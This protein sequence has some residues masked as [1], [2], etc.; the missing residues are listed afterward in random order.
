MARPPSNQVEGE[1]LE[2]VR[3]A[4]LSARQAFELMDGCGVV[5]RVVG[6]AISIFLMDE[7]N[8]A[9]GT[10]STNFVQMPLEHVVESF[11]LIGCTLTHLCAPNPIIPGVQ[12]HLLALH[13]CPWRCFPVT[14]CVVLSKNEARTH[15]PTDRS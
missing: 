1:V 11:Q 10:V 13:Q 14:Q 3:Q 4:S 9:V 15:H 6:R 12:Q 5:R 2:E 7:V 8:K